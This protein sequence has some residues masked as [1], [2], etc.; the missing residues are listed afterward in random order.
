MCFVASWSM[1]LPGVACSFSRGG[2]HGRR[3][4]GGAQRLSHGARP[5]RDVAPRT[6]PSTRGCTRERVQA[7]HR[8]RRRRCAGSRRLGSGLL[9]AEHVAMWSGSIDQSSCR[10]CRAA[11]ARDVRPIP[12]P[13]RARG[14]PTYGPVR[15]SRR[16]PWDPRAAA[17][18]SGP[19]AAGVHF[20]D[21]EY[22]HRARAARLRPRVGAKCR[23]YDHA[24]PSGAPLARRVIARHSCRS[25]VCDRVDPP[26]PASR[27][28]RGSFAEEHVRADAARPAGV[29][30]DPRQRSRVKT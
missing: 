30:A 5:A 15:P 27:P 3:G 2:T 9:A 19:G 18:A 14:R 6:P 20:E 28:S 1:P 11:V 12:E 16:N 25:C 22:A 10:R 23:E 29:R 17:P 13:R 7:R 21:V 8:R 24:F 4:Q 26:T